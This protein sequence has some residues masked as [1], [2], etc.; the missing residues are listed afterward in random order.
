MCNNSI[1][2]IQYKPF[3]K[4]CKM[5]GYQYVHQNISNDTI[6]KKKLSLKNN[7]LINTHQKI[8]NCTVFFLISLGE[9]IP[10]PP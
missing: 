9:H 5:K 8:S 7:Y 10:K 2:F 1:I 3:K 4:N 6:S